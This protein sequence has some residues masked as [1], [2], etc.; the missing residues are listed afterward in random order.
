MN[1]GHLVPLGSS[2]STCSERNFWISGT[3][4]FTG[5]IPPNHRCQSTHGNKECLGVTWLCV[6]E[7]LGVTWLCVCECLGVTWLCVCE[8]LGVTWLCVWVPGCDMPVCVWWQCSNAVESDCAQLDLVG[9][10]I[11]ELC[12]ESDLHCLKRH[13]EQGDVASTLHCCY[14]MYSWSRLPCGV[15]KICCWVDF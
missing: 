8:C 12:H 13:H 4:F 15:S 6:C 7:C 3:G 10:Y 9:K 5:W 11:I 1:L 14:T 2:S